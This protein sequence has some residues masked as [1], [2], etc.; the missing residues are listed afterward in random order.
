MGGFD[1]SSGQGLIDA[2]KKNVDGKVRAKLKESADRGE[3]LSYVGSIDTSTGKVS[4]GLHSLP[5]DDPLAAAKEAETMV[6]FVTERY[7]AGTPLIVRGPGAGA[8][9]TAAGVFADVL[10]L[11]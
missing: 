1:A 6:S 5:V 3:I 10:R 4:V 9:V 8:L 7:P 2:L 11:S